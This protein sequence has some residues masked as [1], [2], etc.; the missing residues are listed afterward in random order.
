MNRETGQYLTG[1]PLVVQS[2]HDVLTTRLWSRVH[3][4][5]YGLSDWVDRV[6]DQASIGRLHS[7]VV[8][9]VLYW[10]PEVSVQRIR[11]TFPDPENLVITIQ[12][13]L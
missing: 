2:I 5:N 3:R 6:M 9:A 11:L 8:S 12:G 1:L 7:Q 10:V 13:R 4:R